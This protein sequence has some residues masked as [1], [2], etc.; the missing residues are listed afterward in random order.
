LVAEV[1]YAQDLARTNPSSFKGWIEYDVEHRVIGNLVCKDSAFD[2][3]QGHDWCE[4]RY[5]LEEGPASLK[6]AVTAMGESEPMGSLKWNNALSK[7]CRDHILDI[8]PLGL[9]GHDGS[10]GDTKADRVNRYASSF[11]LLGENIMYPE[12][13]INV[14]GEGLEMV[15]SMIVD[16][17]IASRGHRN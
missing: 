9:D 1:L 14:E 11:T 4:N 8:G 13:A 2:S 6:E 17:G 3:K 7:S 15:K 16:D 12:S 10:Q 5:E